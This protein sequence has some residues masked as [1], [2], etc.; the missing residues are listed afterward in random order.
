MTRDEA[1]QALQQHLLACLQRAKAGQEVLFSQ[2]WTDLMNNEA[3]YRWVLRA[4]EREDADD[5]TD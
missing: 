2:P 3:F 5:E 4:L 1:I